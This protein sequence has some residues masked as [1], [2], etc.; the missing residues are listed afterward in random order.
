MPSKEHKHS[1]VMKDDRFHDGIGKPTA[2]YK[3]A[4][5]KYKACLGAS[6]DWIDGFADDRDARSA[7]DLLASA[8]SLRLR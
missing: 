6:L 7:L 3:D 2:K 4:A 5:G 8:N 1:Q